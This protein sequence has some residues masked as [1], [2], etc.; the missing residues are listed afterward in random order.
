MRAVVTVGAPMDPVHAEI[1]YDA[2]VET[3]LA[4][5]S[6]TWMVGG[7]ALTL[8]R[9]FVEDV[10]AADLQE[11]IRSLRL[12]LLILHSPTDNTVGIENA[13]RIFQTARHPRSFVSLEG[14][15][16]F[17]SGPEKRGVRDGSSGRGPTRTW[18]TERL[19]GRANAKLRL[20]GRRRSWRETWW[21][22]RLTRTNNR[23]INSR[24]LCQLSYRGLPGTRWLCRE[25]R[26]DSSLRAG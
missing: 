16:T 26:H 11:K 1:Q 17:C 20:T 13:S 9:A 18:A 19:S 5:G 25:P 3:V 15:T 2:V 12:P 8:K 21:L 10:R 22:P 7:K 4:E 23:P 24:M 6:A 14:S